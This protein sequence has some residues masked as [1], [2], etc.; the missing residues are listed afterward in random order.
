MAVNL[1]HRLCC[2]SRYWARSVERD[3]LPWAL[4]GVDGGDNTLEIATDTGPPA[5]EFPFRGVLPMLH[6]VPT[7]FRTGCT[8]RDSVTNR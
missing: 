8:A 6:D 2:R 3:L 7:H 4:A 5:G 1:V